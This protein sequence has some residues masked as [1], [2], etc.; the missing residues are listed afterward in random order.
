M[1]GVVIFIIICAFIFIN[2]GKKKA[3]GSARQANQSRP[4]NPNALANQG[5]P[6]NFGGT[7]NQGHP[8]NQKTPVFQQ[9]STTARPNTSPSFESVRVNYEAPV[10]DDS[11]HPKLG[12]GEGIMGMR[13][14]EWMPVSKGCQVVNCSYC[15]A[16]NEVRSG[17]IRGVK[18]YFCWK[19]L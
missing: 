4:V 15:G 17:K 12:A 19:Q 10:F 8:V 14:E 13:H 9:D 3:D 11:K 16:E 2:A 18:C 6:V 1:G 5:K 7:L